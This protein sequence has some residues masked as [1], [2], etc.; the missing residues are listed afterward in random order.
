MESIS[1]HR[2]RF[3]GDS[4]RGGPILGFAVL[5]C[6]LCMLWPGQ[7]RASSYV[8]HL[9]S[10]GRIATS[11]YWREGPEIRFYA[12]GGVMGVPAKSIVR[13]VRGKTTGETPSGGS[14]PPEPVSPARAKSGEGTPIPSAPGHPPGEKG[15]VGKAPLSPEELQAYTERHRRLKEDLEE[16]TKK[17][18]QAS[19]ARNSE[20]RE[21]ARAEMRRTAGQIYELRDAVKRKNEGKLPEGW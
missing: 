3:P 13:I 7:P 17:M 12:A 8:L 1:A 15:R 21:K 2:R 6:L 20:A 18:R 4:L 11:H 10:G 16:A 5:V 14:R 19:R 9:E